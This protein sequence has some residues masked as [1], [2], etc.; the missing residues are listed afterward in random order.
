[1]KYAIGWHQ[2]HTYHVHS[3]LAIPELNVTH[4]FWDTRYNINYT[5]KGP[6]TQQYLNIY[7]SRHILK[8]WHREYP[9]FFHIIQSSKIFRFGQYMHCLITHISFLGQHKCEHQRKITQRIGWMC[10]IRPLGK[11]IPSKIA[12]VIIQWFFHLYS[13]RIVSWLVTFVS[14]FGLLTEGGTL[15]GADIVFGC[16]WCYYERGR[17]LSELIVNK[18]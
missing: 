14:V 6:A 3:L 9:R 13:F 7:F 10:P 8:K 18:R 4:F 2:N 12:L 15:A 5:K 16:C 11:R 17:R 1:M